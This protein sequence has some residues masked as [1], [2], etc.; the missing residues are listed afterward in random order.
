MASPKVS[1]DCQKKRR[2]SGKPARPYFPANAVH[3]AVVDRG[4]GTE[5][6]GLALRTPLGVFVGPDNGVL[7]PALAEEVRRAAGEGGGRVPLPKGATR[8]G[9]TNARYHPLPVSQTL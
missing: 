9:L 3:I 1:Q 2:R 4:V 6:R 5:R 8:G 7:S